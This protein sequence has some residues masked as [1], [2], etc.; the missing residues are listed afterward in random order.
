MRKKII[1]TAAMSLCVGPSL[2]LWRLPAL[3]LVAWSIIALLLWICRRHVDILLFLVIALAFTA[4]LGL[5]L[6]PYDPA[7]Q[8]MDEGTHLLGLDRSGRDLLSRLLI[9]NRNSVLIA[10]AGSLA[11]CLLGLSIGLGMGYGPRW[12]NWS[13]NRLI[14]AYMIVPILVYFLLGLALFTPGATTLVGLLT[15]TLG[16]D[17]ARI[18]Q[19][20]ITELREARFVQVARMAGMTGPAIVLWEVA[21]NLVR[22]LTVNFLI[23]FGSAIVI[24]SVL[25][26][27]GLGLGVG[28]PSL[29]QLIQYGTQNMD[30]QPLVLPA[31]LAVMLGWIICLRLL[32]QRA[33]A[34]QTL[35]VLA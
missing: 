12:L 18:F 13:L 22:L 8:F 11:A 33:N 5:W 35:P 23:C 7:R 34:P 4:M 9:G 24:E 6:A 29:G 27:L 10:A 30:R 26:Y 2:L 19:V 14:Q 17:Q 32:S 1:V 20:R 31:V 28:T 15:V 16:P 21:P 25:G 3:L